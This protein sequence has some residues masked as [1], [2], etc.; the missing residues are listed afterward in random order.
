MDDKI[1]INRIRMM[2]VQRGGKQAINLSKIDT[3]DDSYAISFN[4]Q[5]SIFILIQTI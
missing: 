3:S 5:S 2:Y 1:N 4:C